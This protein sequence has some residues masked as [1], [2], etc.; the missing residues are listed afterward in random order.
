MPMMRVTL[1]VAIAAC[2]MF[3]QASA[4]PVSRVVSDP[5]RQTAIPFLAE[6]TTRANFSSGLR[7][8]SEITLQE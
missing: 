1:I 4:T 2:T 8:S 3:G 6:A 7:F 5:V